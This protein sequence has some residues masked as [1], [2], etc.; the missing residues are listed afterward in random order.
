ML[1]KN[2]SAT[3]TVQVNLF[4]VNGQNDKKTFTKTEILHITKQHS[5]SSYPSSF[6]K[7][8]DDLD[9]NSRRTEEAEY[10]DIIDD[11]KLSDCKVLEERMK[12]AKI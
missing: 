6:Y 12:I 5:D 11:S 3:K 9:I 2:N 1:K 10:V 7:L 8:Y 4:V